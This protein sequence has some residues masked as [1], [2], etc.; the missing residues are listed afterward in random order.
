MIVFQLVITEPAEHDLHTIIN[1]VSKKLQNPLA[2]KELLNKISHN[3]NHLKTFPNRFPLVNDII[4]ANRG[5]RKAT[6]DNY[7]IF[8]LPLNRPNVAL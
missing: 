2:A 1:Y 3:L 4:L 7:I 5:I 8:I 6:I